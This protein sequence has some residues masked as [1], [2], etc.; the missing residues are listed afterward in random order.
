MG[1]FHFIFIWS[2]SVST[3]SGRPGRPGTSVEQISLSYLHFLTYLLPKA[4][5][6]KIMIELQ[7]VC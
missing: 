3:A 2:L 6:C 1:G 5:F 4:L 7:P